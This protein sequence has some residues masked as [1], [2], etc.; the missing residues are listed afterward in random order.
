MKLSSR[1]A[2]WGNARWKVLVSTLISQ[3]DAFLLPAGV[4]AR[5][6]RSGHTLS[7]AHIFE[8]TLSTSSSSASFFLSAAVRGS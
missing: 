5:I 6:P 7:L 1:L 3:P 2:A 8:T 4:A